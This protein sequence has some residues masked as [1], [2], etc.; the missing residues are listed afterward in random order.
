MGYHIPSD[1][2]VLNSL[3]KVLK[4]FRTVTSQN[5][6]KMGIILIILKFSK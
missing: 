1:E 3:E 5:K 4:K 2:Q 6:L